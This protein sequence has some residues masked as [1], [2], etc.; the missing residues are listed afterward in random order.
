[1]RTVFL[2]SLY[3]A[4]MREG[5]ATMHNFPSVLASR[6]WLWGK[7]DDGARFKALIMLTDFLLNSWQTRER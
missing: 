3:I 6:E 1:M 5:P 4:H 7:N 2:E